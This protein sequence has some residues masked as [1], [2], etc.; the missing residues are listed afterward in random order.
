M[1]L[2]GSYY[3][4]HK[5]ISLCLYNFSEMAIDIDFNQR[6]SKTDLRIPLSRSDPPELL[7]WPSSSGRVSLSIGEVLPS[8]GMTCLL[9]S[10]QTLQLCWALPSS[11]SW[12]NSAAVNRLILKAAKQGSQRTNL[13]PISPEGRGWGIYGATLRRGECGEHGLEIRKR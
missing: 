7:R 9:F 4:W 6:W 11:C 5:S 12:P 10:G 8:A 1:L 3:Y 13:K 2:T